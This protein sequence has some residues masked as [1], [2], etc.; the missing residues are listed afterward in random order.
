MAGTLALTKILD[1]REL[2]KKN[3]QVEYH[4]SVESF[5]QVAT[6]LFQLLKQKESAE[7]MY[8]EALCENMDL[9]QIQDQIAYIET[10]NKRIIV[11]QEQVQQARTQMETKQVL[12][13]EAHVE[14]KKFEK[15]IEFRTREELE[16][17]KKEEKAL[18]DD[19]SIQQYLSHK[20]R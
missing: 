16:V 4:Q 12:L 7:E 18:M 10:L 14:A 1:I 5:E 13:S 20:N 6:K 19:I 3:A 15:I 9:E 11:L 17:I 8:E 2:E